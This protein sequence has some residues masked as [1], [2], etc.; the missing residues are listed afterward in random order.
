MESQKLR[1][2][3]VRK[4]DDGKITAA[5]TE[6][7][8]G[9]LDEG[10]VVIR[11]EFSGVNYK[12]ALAATGAGRGIMRDFPKV[13]G[14]DVAGVVAESSDSRYRPGDKVLITGYKLGVDHDG[15]FAEF[16]RASAD[17]L[18]PL[19]GGI[20]A[21][22]AMTVGTAGFT[23]ALSVMRLMENGLAP[24]KRKSHR[25][26]RDRRRRRIRRGLPR[27]TRISSNRCHR[28]G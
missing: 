23:A 2:L 3:Q 12:D 14:I 1:A 16:V 4:D 20:S 19:P 27:Q 11:A 25:A 13:A 24:G 10:N 5:V 8:V 6:M 15:G 17:W 9:D 28:Q 26:G 18:V 21:R 7:T 22:E